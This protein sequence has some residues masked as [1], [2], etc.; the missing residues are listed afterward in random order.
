[1]KSILTLAL[2]YGALVIPLGLPGVVE[3]GTSQQSGSN[4]S[5]GSTPRPPSRWWTIEKY[6][7]ELKLTVEQSAEIERV[8]QSSMARLKADK[9]AVPTRSPM[10]SGDIVRVRHR[11]SRRDSG[12]GYGRTRPLTSIGANSSE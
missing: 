5:H 3:A 4:D 9:G 11:A 10:A 1:M 7:Q 12:F 8:V 2:M 6:K